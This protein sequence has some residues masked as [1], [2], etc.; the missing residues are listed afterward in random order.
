MATGAL[1][2]VTLLEFSIADIAGHPRGPTWSEVSSRQQ[3]RGAARRGSY[4]PFGQCE[5]DQ[6][7]ASGLFP[8]I[9]TEVPNGTQLQTTER[10]RT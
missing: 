7:I 3:C 8:L 2:N 9:R 10:A 1:Q 5:R 6:G 4:W